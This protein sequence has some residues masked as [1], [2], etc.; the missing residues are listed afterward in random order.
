MSVRS[1]RSGGP[2]RRLTLASS[3]ISTTVLASLTRRVSTATLRSLD[4]RRVASGLLSPDPLRG[5][6]MSNTLITLRRSL[7]GLSSGRIALDRSSSGDPGN[8]LSSLGGVASRSAKSSS[9]LIVAGDSL[10]CPMGESGES[11]WTCWSKYEL[12]SIDCGMGE[13]SG[14]VMGRAI[15]GVDGAD[16]AEGRVLADRVGA[17][18]G[19]ATDGG[20]L[21]CGAE[22]IMGVNGTGADGGLVLRPRPADVSRKCR[23]VRSALVSIGSSA[24]AG[25]E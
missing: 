8:V 10:P 3:W 20:R 17:G 15:T 7:E 5:A 6:S 21:R 13:S 4:S 18:R 12:G 22:L 24:T 23:D 11:E 25:K 16:G 1:T 9:D 19:P 14:G 2:S